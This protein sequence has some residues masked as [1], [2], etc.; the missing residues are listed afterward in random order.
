MIRKA[1]DTSFT[2]H[3]ARKGVECLKVDYQY[4]QYKFELS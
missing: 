2:D 4:N 1:G 3:F